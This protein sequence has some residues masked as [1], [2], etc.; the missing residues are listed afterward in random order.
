M[1][2]RNDEVGGLLQEYAD[3]L[4]ITGGEEFKARVYEKAARAVAGHHQDVT[5]L[6]KDELKKIP[7]VGSS[8]AE[9]LT[10]YNETGHLRALEELRAK[11][12]AGVRQLISI[13][14]LGPRKAAVLYQDLGIASVEELVDA[15]RQERLR[16]LKGFGVKT[17]AQLLHGIEL[18]QHAG[19]RIHINL[20]MELAEDIVA[21]LS[22][23]PGCD[24]CCYAGSL[25]RMKETIGDIDIL[26]A[27]EAAPAAALMKAF[28]SLPYVDEV[29]AAGGTKSS[30]RTV[31]GVQVDLRVL[32]EAAWG[33]ALQ[34]FTGSKA[35]NLRTREI[36]VHNG[37]KLS[38]YGLFD[39]ETDQLIVS[40]TEE[41]VYERLGL[42]WMPPQL[43]EDRG[44][45]E[46]AR[47]GEQPILVTDEDI[48]GDLHTHTNL[49]DGVSSLEDMLQ[50]AADL[51]YAYYA[52]TDH[53]PNLYMQ[54]M[55]D[56]KMLG[57]RQ[58]VRAL[59]GKDATMQ[60]LHGTELNIG[61]DGDVDWPPEFL[62]GFDL[63]VASVHS[64]FDQDRAVMTRR[65]L[66]AVANP[67]VN[68]I[69]H[70]T[71][72]LIDR[73]RGIDAD[74]DEVYK[75]CARTGTALEINAFPDRLDLNDEE[76]LRARRYGVK[77]AIDSD[78]HS[79][80]HL[81]FLRYG[82]GMAQRGWL[83][84]DDVINTWPL[85]RL[86]AFLARRRQGET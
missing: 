2:W 60:L 44:E 79:T 12:P 57:Q 48:K 28:T 68:I 37:L 31:K 61:P 8:I 11:I 35:H 64:H 43:R 66:R 5:K 4:R 85:P 7:G 56:A 26:A 45:I 9:K 84:A 52:I 59:N 10:E 6:G 53:A 81:G 51:G 40:K 73:R 3:L 50:A 67:Y 54:R 77:F 70:P 55:S 86:R 58:R 47:R 16:G 34:Y 65:L 13:P 74:L 39:A 25:R 63:C 29:I 80:V 33:A 15:I 83:T 75:A 71:A 24:R 38:E 36:A 21:E 76:I 27:A 19:E 32:P 14:T 1:A 41:E 22:M 20:A 30:I 69:G 49:T 17:E 46:A 82:V 62:D 78:A 18:M 42:P 23:V 72:R